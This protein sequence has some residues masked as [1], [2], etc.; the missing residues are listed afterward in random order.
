LDELKLNGIDTSAFLSPVDLTLGTIER[1]LQI[2]AVLGGLSISAALEL[3]QLQ[4][5]FLVLGL[6][7]LWSVDFVSILPLSFKKNYHLTD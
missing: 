5:L 3:S 7:S 6:L 1:N 4:I 2:A